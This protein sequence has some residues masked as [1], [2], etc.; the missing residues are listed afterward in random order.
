MALAAGVNVWLKSLLTEFKA[1]EAHTSFIMWQRQAFSFKPKMHARMKYVKINFHFVRD[2]IMDQKLDVKF[3][4][5]E[6][7]VTYILTKPLVQMCFLSLK[8]KLIVFPP[9]KLKGG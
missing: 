4:P 2:L 5:C 9:S 6:D 1:K 8:T 7:H 3:T